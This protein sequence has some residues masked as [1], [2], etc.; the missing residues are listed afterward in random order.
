M[1]VGTLS[2]AYIFFAVR[3]GAPRSTV[4]WGATAEGSGRSDG[5]GAFADR[6]A[7]VPGVEGDSLV[8]L[9]DSTFGWFPSPRGVRSRGGEEGWSLC[10]E[11]VGYVLAGVALSLK[12]ACHV[13]STDEGSFSQ[14]SRISSINQEF[15]PNASCESGVDIFASGCCHDPLT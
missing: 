2:E 3:I 7:P 5:F 15:A 11:E 14:A 12:K 10:T 1:A 9:T 6:P 8:G 4:R 13:S